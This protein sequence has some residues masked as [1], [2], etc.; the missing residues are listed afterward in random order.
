MIAFLRTFPGGWSARLAL[1]FLVLMVLAAIFGPALGLADPY[2]IDAANL[3]SSP[4]S[5]HWLGTDELG[6]DLLSRAVHGARVSLT[7]AAAAVVLAGVLGVAV[8]VG[9]AFLGRRLEA[10]AIRAVDVFVSLPEIFVALVVL[11]FIG[12]NLPTLVATI[13]LLY[14]PQFAR[15]AWGVA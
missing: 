2:Q 12:G 5:K 15:V 9:V 4:S 7:V 14:A 8:G 10:A 1:G 3:L 6:R 13:G 11:A